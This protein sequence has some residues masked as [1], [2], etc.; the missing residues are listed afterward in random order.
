[1]FVCVNVFYAC[2]FG[3]TFLK[4]R[5]QSANALRQHSSRS[6]IYSFIYVLGVCLFWVVN[7]G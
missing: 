6:Y 4:M 1:M 7:V 5:Q 3:I 2:G